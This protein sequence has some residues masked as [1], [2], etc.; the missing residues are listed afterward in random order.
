[1]T[2]TPDTP[3]D[4][5]IVAAL[6]RRAM[7][8]RRYSRFVVLA[9]RLLPIIAF[10]LLLFVGIWPLLQAELHRAR[11]TLLRLDSREAQD[12]RAVDARYIGI[13]PENRPFVITA[14][15]A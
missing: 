10:I 14:D 4:A 3:S 8:D 13:D 9:K 12:S 6:S 5:Q 15:V 1:M 2:V 11:I 7:V